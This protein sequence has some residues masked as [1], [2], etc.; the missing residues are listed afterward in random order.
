[1]SGCTAPRSGL[2]WDIL[3]AAPETY[4]KDGGLPGYSTYLILMPSTNAAVL[5]LINSWNGAGV[6]PKVGTEILYALY[7]AGLIGK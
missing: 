1:L 7:H 2:A 4:A 3:V 5:V 6:A